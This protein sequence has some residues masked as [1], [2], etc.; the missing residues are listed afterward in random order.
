MNARLERKLRLLAGVVAAGI[1]SGI[2]F[3]I[4]QGRNLVV[5]IAYGLL[6]SLA[7]GRRTGGHSTHARHT[8]LLLLS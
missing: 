2:A 8:P 3:N 7:L 5:G 1:I 6:I 4:A